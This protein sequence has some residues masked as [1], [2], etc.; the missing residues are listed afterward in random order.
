MALDPDVTRVTMNAGYNRLLGLKPGTVSPNVRPDAAALYKD[1]RIARTEI[2]SDGDRAF[3]LVRRNT[4]LDSQ[5][6]YL[7]Y[8]PLKP[9]TYVPTRR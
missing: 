2:L 1:G 9:Q 4:K 3:D 7:G 5:L 8:K 6:E